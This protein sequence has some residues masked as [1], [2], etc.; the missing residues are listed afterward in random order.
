MLMAAAV[1]AF[2]LAAAD[3]YTIYPIPHAQIAGKAA[4]SLSATTTVIA[5]SGIDQPTKNRLCDVLKQ[6]GIVAEF[7]AKPF[8]THLHCISNAM[9]GFL[10]GANGEVAACHPFYDCEYSRLTFL[11]F[12]KHSV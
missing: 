12:A 11:L 5:E 2:T 8:M 4:C 1:C 6:H 10:T 3:A 7:A 9:T